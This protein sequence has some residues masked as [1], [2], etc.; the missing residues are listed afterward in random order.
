MIE[1]INVWSTLRTDLGGDRPVGQEL[2]VA[3]MGFNPSQLQ[4]FPIS[5]QVYSWVGTLDA[6]AL[7]CIGRSKTP[8]RSA[9]RHIDDVVNRAKSGSMYRG[10]NWWESPPSLR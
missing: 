3:G 2:L 10:H 9:S 7:Y 6:K 8:N 4:S 5:Q 1:I